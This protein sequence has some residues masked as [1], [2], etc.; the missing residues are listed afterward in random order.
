MCACM[1][2]VKYFSNTGSLPSPPP[3]ERRSANNSWLRSGEEGKCCCWGPEVGISAIIVDG[4]EGLAAV[5]CA[6]VGMVGCE[7]IVGC[8][9]NAEEGICLNHFG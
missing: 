3:P 6:R 5:G 1:L 8:V 2:A 7:V 9:G 4:C